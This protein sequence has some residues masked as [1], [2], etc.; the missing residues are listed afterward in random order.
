M[1]VESG[2][3]VAICLNWLRAVLVVEWVTSRRNAIVRGESSDKFMTP[4]SNY[5]RAFDKPILSRIVM[6]RLSGFEQNL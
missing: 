4:L 2:A 1:A 6:L 5:E 3:P